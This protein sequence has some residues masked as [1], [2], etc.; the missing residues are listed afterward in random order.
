MNWQEW[1]IYVWGVCVGLFVIPWVLGCAIPVKESL[2]PRGVDVYGGTGQSR[3][4]GD[5]QRDWNVG[6]NVHW[7]IY[8]E[9][10]R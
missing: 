3:F 9:D 7:D 1:A 2:R 8:Y 6:A 4:Y 10:E 5:T